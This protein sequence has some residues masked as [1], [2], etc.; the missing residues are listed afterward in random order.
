MNKQFFCLFL[1][2]IY[3]KLQQGDS[4]ASLAKD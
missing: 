1:D 4:L 2:A 3:P